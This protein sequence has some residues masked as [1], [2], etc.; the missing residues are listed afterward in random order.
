MLYDYR[1]GSRERQGIYMGEV[2]CIGNVCIYPVEVWSRENHYSSQQAVDRGEE[3]AVTR[4]VYIQLPKGAKGLRGKYAFAKS[5]I[6]LN[7]L[8]S[9]PAP[10]TSGV[11]RSSCFATRFSYYTIDRYL[12]FLSKTLL[13]DMHALRETKRDLV[14][15]TKAHRLLPINPAIL[16]FNNA[17]YMQSDEDLSFG[18]GMGALLFATDGDIVL[19]ETSHWVI[20]MINP[21]LISSYFGAGLSIHEGC[22]DV[23]PAL[24]FGDAQI[25]EDIGFIKNARGTMHGLRTVNNSS[26]FKD[27]FGGKSIEMD[28]HI[29]GKVYSG[30]WWSVSKKLESRLR[31]NNSDYKQNK[32]KYNRLARQATMKLILVHIASYPSETPKF[33]DFRAAA[34]QSAR[35]LVKADVIRELTKHGVGLKEMEHV[36]NSEAKARGI[37]FIIEQESA[38]PGKAVAAKLV[39]SEEQGRKI[40]LKALKTFYKKKLAERSRSATAI[41]DI[42]SSMR[43]S[44]PSFSTTAG[45]E[46]VAPRWFKKVV[47]GHPRAISKSSR[48]WHY[49]VGPASVAIARDTGEVVSLTVRG[50]VN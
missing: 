22:A 33:S 45:V 48:V 28:P 49:R 2:D 38:K 17:F 6:P 5:N 24:Y 50:L 41:A 19:H 3:K 37:D 39:V 30:F 35:S 40:A 27:I 12:H 15:K 23:L 42:K 11:K 34:I 10:N 21:N 47:K 46:T 7:K 31:I 16:D 4:T 20:D 32:A 14:P 13:I 18:D 8:L 9:C 25:A 1:G 36:I 44:L 26:N 43:K 29:I